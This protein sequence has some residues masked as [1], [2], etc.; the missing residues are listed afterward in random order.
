MFT[1]LAGSLIKGTKG[2]ITTLFLKIDFD[3]ISLIR[4]I[5]FYNLG[6]KY[7]GSYG[8]TF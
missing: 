5:L 4:S 8:K 1:R 7:I 2:G 6:Q 3:E